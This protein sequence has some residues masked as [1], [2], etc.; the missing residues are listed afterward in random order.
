M[1]P[2]FILG[3]LCTAAVILLV[4]RVSMGGAKNCY[5]GG[6]WKFYDDRWA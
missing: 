2:E 6:Y 1:I 4:I 5:H 3:C